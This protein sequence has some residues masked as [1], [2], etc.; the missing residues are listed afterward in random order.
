M[1]QRVARQLQPPPDCISTPGMSRAQVVALEAQG[2]WKVD[3][4][5]PPGRSRCEVLILPRQGKPP[6]AS[7]L[8]VARERRV[9]SD[10]DVIDI[11]RR[12]GP[13]R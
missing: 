4:V 5:T 3:A 9:R 13:A 1:V 10:D 7:W 2:G 11:Y 8:F 6:D 12:A